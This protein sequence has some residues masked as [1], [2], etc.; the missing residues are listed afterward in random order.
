MVDGQPVVTGDNQ[1]LG[2]VCERTR[3]SNMSFLLPTS[4]LTF[5]L[6]R[7]RSNLYRGPEG[8]AGVVTR[9]QA[10]RSRNC[11]SIPEKEQEFFFKASR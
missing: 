10:V 11:D 8:S 9:L 1:I 6:L 7:Y 4:R 3:R 5:G 2:P